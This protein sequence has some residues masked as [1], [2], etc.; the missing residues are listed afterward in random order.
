MGATA[1]NLQAKPH[2]NTM[3]S[4]FGNF[5]EGGAV[6]NLN[7]WAGYQNPNVDVAES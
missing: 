7:E 2:R 4:G 5:P 6:A 3:V 1:G